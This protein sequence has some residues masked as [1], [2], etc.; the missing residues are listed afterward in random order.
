MELRPA[1]NGNSREVSPTPFKGGFMDKTLLVPLDNTEVSEKMIREADAWA[2]HLGS[3]VSF[4]HVINPNYSWGEEKK[5]LFEERF[6]KAI[7]SCEV[8]SK[9]EVLFRVGKPYP[10]ILEMEEEL[11]PLM[12]LMAAHDHTVLERLFLGSNTDH[13]LHHGHTPVMVYKGLSEEMENKILVPIDYTDI[14]R[15]FCKK[16][17]NGHCGMM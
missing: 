8:K 1:F 15:V 5:P 7:H 16:Q 11:K 10:K 14:S 13:I 6:E 12:I 3:R 4:L 17:T 2:A 9:Y